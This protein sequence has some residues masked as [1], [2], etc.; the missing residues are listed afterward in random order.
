MIGTA[1]SPWPR[2]TVEEAEAV[3]ARSV[4]QPGEL[5]DWRRVPSVRA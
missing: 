2:F 1:F 5:L 3:L 4:E